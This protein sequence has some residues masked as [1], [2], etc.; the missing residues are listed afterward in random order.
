M[1]THSS[2]L[3]WRIPWTEE[4]GGLQFVGSQRVRLDWVTK[5]SNEASYLLGY[6]SC[7][8][9]SSPTPHPRPEALSKDGSY[10]LTFQ[11]APGATTSPPKHRCL[12]FSGSS[13][14]KRMRRKL[15]SVPDFLKQ[16]FISVFL[17][18][19]QNKYTA[20]WLLKTSPVSYYS[21]CMCV[22]CSVMS[23]S[24]RPLQAPLSM[25]FP[26]I[27]EWVGIPFSRGSSQPS[28]WTLVSCN[29]GRFFTVRVTREA[30]R[31]W[32]HG[33]RSCHCAYH[34]IPLHWI[35][36]VSMSLFIFRALRKMWNPSHLCWDIL[37]LHRWD[38]QR[39]K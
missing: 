33:H 23:E 30:K 4:S 1:A 7:I 21:I 34:I 24:L 32:L 38:L 3:A 19:L 13:R 17:L 27:L 14:R 28:G 25:R 8:L 11:I 18:L 20:N 37:L 6:P 35:T 12:L 36:C 29:A 16:D 9:P 22:S 26:R 39:I 15:K 10:L 2:I 5:Y 31:W